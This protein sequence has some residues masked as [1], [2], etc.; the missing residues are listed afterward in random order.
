MGRK[1]QTEQTVAELAGKIYQGDGDNWNRHSGQFTTAS[2]A[3]TVSIDGLM[4]A[5]LAVL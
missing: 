2:V 5:S 1:E 3:E 4:A